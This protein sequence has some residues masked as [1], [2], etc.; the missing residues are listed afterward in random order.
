MTDNREQIPW[1]FESITIGTG[2]SIKDLILTIEHGTLNAGDYSIKGMEDLVAIERK[3]KEDLFATLSRGRERF[4]RELSKLNDMD[5]AAV[6]VEAEWSDC[7]RNP[8]EHSRLAPVSLNGM[9]VAWQV[10]YP[11]VHWW[12]M[13]GRYVASKQAFKLMDRFWQE[14]NG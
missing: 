7:M 11:R 6:M 2:K 12:W 8:P 13:P 5:F 14:K 10:R 4:I 9:I 1:T 3:S